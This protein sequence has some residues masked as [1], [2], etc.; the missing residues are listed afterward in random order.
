MTGTDEAEKRKTTG[1]WTPVGM[2]AR[3]EF[4][5]ETT[6]AMARS[7]E[8]CE[9]EIDLLDRRT[10]K[11]LALQPLDVLTLLVRPNSL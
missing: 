3:I 1:G 7:I 10:L 11:G 9:V 6:C 4:T 8:T 2:T 5:E